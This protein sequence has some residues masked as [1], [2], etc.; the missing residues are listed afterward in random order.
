[1]T[2]FIRILS[3]TLLLCFSSTAALAVDSQ[4]LPDV[5]V[6]IVSIKITEPN[7]RVGYTVGDIIE[8]EVMLTIKA[9]YK[10]IDTSLPIVGYEKRY[11]GQVIGI[12]LKSIQHT[13]EDHTDYS[14]HN[15]KLA[16]QIF[17]NSVVAKNATLGPEYLNLINTKNSKDL[18]K[19]RIPSFDITVSPLSVFGQVKLEENISPFLGPI[20]L[21]DASE[22]TRLKIALSF[23]VLSLLGLLYIFGRHAWLP[24][25]GGNFAKAYRAI[26]KL[27][28]NNDGLKQ[29]I[30]ILHQ[31][32]NSTADMSVFNDNLESFL[33]KHTKY[34]SLKT[35]FQQFFGL[36]RQVYFEPSFKN[37]AKTPTRAWLLQFTRRCRDCERGLNPTPIKVED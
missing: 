29:S 11:K 19:Y 30:S 32:L 14:A 9:P 37:N 33:A 10:L 28:D 1:M 6:G 31:S 26:R 17:T 27:P 5:K 34:S 20:L 21:N 22:Q 24:K 4:E 15:I 16:Y 18:V 13:K 2:K 3:L 25:M 23:L 36:S 8:R 35:E 12:E 7:R